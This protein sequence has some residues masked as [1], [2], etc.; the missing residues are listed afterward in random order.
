[1][2]TF[3]K[4]FYRVTCS[5]LTILNHLIFLKS[6]PKPHHGCFL[7]RF[8]LFDAVIECRQNLLKRLLCAR[9]HENALQAASI[10]FGYPSTN[11]INNGACG[12]YTRLYSHLLTFNPTRVSAAMLA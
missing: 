1:M 3:K 8:K 7:N 12:L 2:K 11:L 4:P 10:I 6:L 5:R 9:T